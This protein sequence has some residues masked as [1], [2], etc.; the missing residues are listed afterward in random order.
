MNEQQLQAVAKRFGR[1]PLTVRPCAFCEGGTRTTLLG[2]TLVCRDCEGFNALCNQCGESLERCE[3]NGVLELCEGGCGRV[4]TQC[5][6]KAK[7]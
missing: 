3:C 6:C 5:K 1:G 7:S 4:P 2:L